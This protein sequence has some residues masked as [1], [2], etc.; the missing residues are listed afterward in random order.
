MSELDGA[1]LLHIKD[2]IINNSLNKILLNNK[3]KYFLTG[4]ISVPFSEF[5][6]V[7]MLDDISYVSIQRFKFNF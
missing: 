6:A 2:L 7:I 3:Y 4:D 1:E 5:T